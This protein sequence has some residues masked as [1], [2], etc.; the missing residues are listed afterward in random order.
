MPQTVKADRLQNLS[1]LCYSGK[2]VA[3]LFAGLQGKA[4]DLASEAALHIFHGGHLHGVPLDAGTVP[5][6]G[7]FLRKRPQRR[8]LLAGKA[9]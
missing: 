6:G 9:G 2:P 8:L 4:E 3:C 1:A 7:E 5:Q